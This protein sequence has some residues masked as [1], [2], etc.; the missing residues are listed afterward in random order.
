VHYDFDK[1]R[2]VSAVEVYWF[3]DTGGGSCRVP[4]SWKL[5]YLKDGKWKPVEGTSEYGTKPD[6]YNRVSFDAVEAT[7]V[8]IEVQLQTKYSGGILEW[9]VQ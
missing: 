4:Q 8:R 7:A 6:K 1:P 3:D 5:L 2:K 9:K